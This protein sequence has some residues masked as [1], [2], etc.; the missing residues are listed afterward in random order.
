MPHTNPMRKRGPG[1]FPRLRFGLLY[2]SLMLTVLGVPLSQDC[3]AEFRDSFE[4]EV[5][6]WRVADADCPVK[7]LTHSRTTAV[8]HSGQSCEYFRMVAG[9]GTF[10]HL[11]QSVPEAHV[12]PDLVPSI[13]V[14]SDQAGLQLMVRVI[15]P[16]SLMPRTKRPIVALLR[17]DSY[18]QAGSWQQLRVPSIDTLIKREVLQL[19]TK[20]GPHVD[21]REAYIDAFVLNA[22]G[23]AG[24]SELWVDDL[25]M[26]GF[27]ALDKTKDFSL[28]SATVQL[29]THEEDAQPTG[30]VTHG[31]LQGDVLSAAGRPLMPRVVDWNGEP[32][33]WIKSLGFNAIRTQS[34]LSP[35]HLAE[36]ARLDLWLITNPPTEAEIHQTSPGASRLLAAELGRSIN[37]I[38]L[39]AIRQTVSQLRGTPIWSRLPLFG[40]V[41]LNNLPSEFPWDIVSA[42]FDVLGTSVDF[43]HRGHQIRKLTSASEQRHY[44]AEI[45]TEP[46]IE[47]SEQSQLLAPPVSTSIDLDLEQLRLM[48]FVATAMGVRGFVFPSRTRLDLP[49][50]EARAIALKWINQELSWIEP[51]C[52]GGKYAGTIEHPKA[53]VGVWDTE[54]GRLL[55]IV[56]PR[57]HEQCVT[58]PDT[59]ES[60]SLLTRF[61]QNSALAYQLTSHGI[62]PLKSRRESGGLG[63]TLEAASRIELVVVTADP[64]VVNH[65]A[66]QITD[67]RASVAR[68]RLNALDH[69]LRSTDEVVRVARG[70]SINFSPIEAR[71]DDA[72]ANSRQCSR[73]L[74]NN[75]Y[76]NFAKFFEITN[77]QLSHI[78]WILWRQSVP[79]NMR[80]AENPASLLF[81]TLPHLWLS[82]QTLSEADWQDRELNDGNF[83]TLERLL[84][85]GWRQ[86]RATGDGAEG[87]AELSPEFPHSGRM[88]LHLKLSGDGETH[89]GISP[90]LSISTPAMHVE[91]GQWLR[92]QG[93]VRI[94]KRL[95]SADGAMV[96]ESI[97]GTALAKRIHSTNAWEQF[98]L[99]RAAPRSEPLTVTLALT[100]DG[101]VY[102]DDISI[103]A[104]DVGDKPAR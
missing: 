102:W 21:R 61:N 104:V 18:T 14:K 24:P 3:Y 50:H 62:V 26:T 16:R 101:D 81:S 64:I 72:R 51:W 13:W 90:R 56:R 8:F 55:V 48:T 39:P 43:P 46:S 70:V 95:S 12:I 32:L 52:A 44:W 88:S 71:L 99:Y 94:P 33:E 63:L 30:P 29:A 97:G 77:E 80:L 42:P 82:A 54:R 47:L 36:L 87:I 79:N 59:K 85:S 92:I 28:D 22:L 9:Q 6:S 83:E 41:G 75:D 10:V 53:Q 25:E 19:R 78:R 23:Q 84:S 35:E 96:I 68:L 2:G 93:W 27:A 73:M 4:S 49:D 66:R 20:F 69:R 17:G 98:T 65:L 89:S 34:Y 74:D 60:I 103:S 38:D 57:S 1:E 67:R 5:P 11:I 86:Q 7:L 31:E 40:S 58:V 37:A 91:Q 45:P 100:C 76:Q 15:L